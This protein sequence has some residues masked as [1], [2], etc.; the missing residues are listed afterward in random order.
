MED[1]SCKIK[2][3]STLGKVYIEFSEE[4]EQFDKSYVNESSLMI[5]VVPSIEISP[6]EQSL[7]E[8]KKHAFS[9]EV[10]QFYSNKLYIQ[11]K[12]EY[13]LW[14]S[15]NFEQ[16]ILQI[17]FYNNSSLF[18]ADKTKKPLDHDYLVTSKIRP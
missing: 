14:I 2:S 10:L 16:D 17:T 18:R 11:L 7:E 9:W 1:L 4:V 3:L 5:K 13:P 6:D 12:F 15:S 8:Q